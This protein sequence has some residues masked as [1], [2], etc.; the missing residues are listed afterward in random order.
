MNWENKDGNSVHGDY[1]V[2]LKVNLRH[3][4]PVCKWLH[5]SLRSVPFMQVRIVLRD[6]DTGLYY[7]SPEAWARNGYDALTFSNIIEAETF[8]R[9]RGL[10]GLKCIQQSG[11]FFA[12]QRHPNAGWRLEPA[13]RVSGN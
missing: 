6:P 10:R 4:V 8:C 12:R 11:Y 9:T 1:P 3:K 5:C 2:P 7:R 13:S